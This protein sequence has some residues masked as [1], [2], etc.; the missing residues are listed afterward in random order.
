LLEALA[1]NAKAEI[2]QMGVTENR[3]KCK[4]FDN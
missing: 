1:A 4:Y 2:Q 3:E